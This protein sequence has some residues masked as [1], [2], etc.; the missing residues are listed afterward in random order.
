MKKSLAAALAACVLSLAPAAS[1]AK[2]STKKLN[3]VVHVCTKK[4]SSVDAL[5]CNIYKEGRGESLNGQ[6]AIAFVTMNR[7]MHDKFP[8]SVRRVVYQP[9]Q[10]S[11]TNDN[12]PGY[13]IRDAEAW[14]T[15][16]KIAKFVYRIRNKTSLYNLLD[17]TNGSIYYHHTGIRP[18]W[19]KHFK[20]TVTIDNHV[21]YKAK[22]KS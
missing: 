22:E 4:D 20:K 17:N 3:P 12:R 1:Y 15:A 18:Y 21:F 9:S 16:H 8:S 7:A 19:S 5:A 11:W 13:K 14:E 6:M 2:E 10:F